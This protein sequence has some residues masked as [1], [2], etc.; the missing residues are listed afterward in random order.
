VRPVGIVLAAGRGT[1]LATR[2]AKPAVRVAG[3]SMV[4]H[5]LHALAG[6]GPEAVVVV[7]GERRGEV[8][9]AAR[10]DRP[11]GLLVR[12]APQVAP[13][14]T[15][16]ALEAALVAVPELAAHP[17]VVVPGDAPLLGPEVLSLLLGRLA[18]TGAA[19]VLLTAELADP[20]G[21]GRVV[22]DAGGEL[23]RLVEEA[24]AD[25]PTRAIREVGTSV[26]AFAPGV[27]GSAVGAIGADN[28]K[29]ERYLTDIVA[30]LVGRGERVE[31]VN[32]PVPFDAFG[33]NDLGQLATA[34][35]ELRARLL[36]RWLAAGVRALDP[37]TVALDADCR[38]AAGV[39]LHPHVVVAGRTI[40]AEDAEIGPF[41]R[42]VDTVVGA[43]ARLVAVDA[44]DA[45]F[46]PGEECGPFV[47]RRGG[48][49]SDPS[50]SAG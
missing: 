7:V 34:E 10:A 5:A 3:R 11:D 20:T 14:G 6:L 17:L 2:V 21:Y 44:V 35:A 47:V 46:A 28:A 13:Q 45:V 12:F 43:G 19:A 16:D 22:R 4:G 32:A 24:D 15:A 29:G 50:R 36:R 30:V 8:E 1:R 33:V 26:Y 39:V 41:C 49:A 42:L 23:V 25:A 27:A 48:S 40:V 31:T 38:L 18:E 9:A 37:G